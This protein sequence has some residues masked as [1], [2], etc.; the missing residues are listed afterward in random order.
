MSKGHMQDLQGFRTISSPSASPVD[1]YAGGVNAPKVTAAEQLANAFGVVSKYGQRAVAKQQAEEAEL[2][3]MQA[4]AYLDRFEGEDG[5]YMDS[6]KLGETYSHL[7]ETVVATL[8]EDKHNK[9]FYNSAIEQ[10]SSLDND[11]KMDAVEVEREFDRLL[12]E[13]D[14]STKGMPFVSSGA[15]L[16]V[17][18]AI[19]EKRREFSLQ[20]DAYT[21]K[22]FQAN[23]QA[24]VAD[25]LGKFDLN[26]NDGQMSTV[27]LMNEFNQKLLETSPFTKTQDKNQIVDAVIAYN[28]TNPDSNA[29][30]LIERIPYL[31]SKVTEQK[32]NEA[33]PVIAQLGIQKLTLDAKKRQFADAQVL[34]E[35]AQEFNT[36]AIANNLDGIRKAMAK[37]TT[38]KGKDAQLG[39][40]MFKLAETALVS[41]QVD[42]EQSQNF[43]A[44]FEA[45]LV[46]KAIK[47]ELT[48]KDAIVA[49][50]SS[51]DM[52]P[53]DKEAIRGKLDSIMA[54]N[55]LI[56]ASKHSTEFD[57]RIGDE[58]RAIDQSI[59][60]LTGKIEGRSLE[61]RVRDLWDDTVY[62]LIVEYATENNAK[63]E[64]RALR[65]LYDEAEAITERRMAKLRGG[66]VSSSVPPNRRSIQEADSPDLP[67]VTTQEEYDALESG[68]QY[69]ENGKIFKKP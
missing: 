8:V 28:K 10:L 64:G 45:G 27:L 34:A 26:T 49:I 31:Q 24:N 35:A 44:T 65:K 61:S 22:Q 47:G 59:L 20:R 55:D 7:S 11:K 3:K 18:R 37:A 48:R 57:N 43:A 50:E 53:Q 42:V 30:A 5:E 63:P 68:E 52:R 2:G 4:K 6:V 17:K 19:N 39:A 21:R 38:L 54:G 67:T 14:G 32:I 51:T 62:E 23:T 15:R 46:V 60:N 69:L 16:G 1:A 25:I 36:M 41:A 12:S 13:A 33:R 56:A 58:A 9:Q 66:S 29:I 40:D